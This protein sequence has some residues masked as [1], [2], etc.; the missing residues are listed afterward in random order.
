MDRDWSPGLADAHLLLGGWRRLRVWGG[1]DHQ[2]VTR[3]LI[4][5]QDVYRGQG[6]ERGEHAADLLQDIWD[7]RGGRDEDRLTDLTGNVP[8][9]GEQLQ[10][11][12]A[13]EEGVGTGGDSRDAAAHVSNQMMTGFKPNV[14]HN[15]MFICQQKQM[16]VKQ[17]RMLPTHEVLIGNTM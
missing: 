8:R 11:G 4:L 2:L 14:R 12:Q 15:Y 9:D 7:V 5:E 16:R 13:G 1:G 10:A 6:D 3:E 17:A